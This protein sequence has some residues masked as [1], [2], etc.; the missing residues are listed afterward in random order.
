[1]YNTRKEALQNNASQYFTGAVC[2]NGHIAARRAKTGEC[3]KCRTVA[4]KQW[5]TKNPSTV[6]AHNKAQYAVH[7][8]KIT[9]AVRKYRL[10][11]LQEVNSKKRVYQQQ[12]RNVFNAIA[13]RRKAS[14]L[15]RTPVWL[16][17]DDHWLISEAYALATLRTKLFGFAWH[18]DHIIPLQGKRVSGLHV[19]RNLQVI[20]GVLNR[21]KS[22]NFE[23]VQ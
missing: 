4:L 18:V 21:Q 8:Q 19:P 2:C 5:R 13:A 7:A 22:N 23:P 6:Q 15:Q 3:L 16:T 17:D 12:N 9:A 11:N 20:P 10:N 1:M 14:Q